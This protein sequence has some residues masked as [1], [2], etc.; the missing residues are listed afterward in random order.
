MFRNGTVRKV[1]IGVSIAALFIGVGGI[2]QASPKRGGTIIEAMGTEPTNLDIFRAARRPE[3]TILQLMIE[4]LFVTNDKLE[5]EGLL[6]E[7]GSCN[8]DASV[9]TVKLKKGIIFHDGTPLTAEA[10]K[11]SMERH[12]KGSSGK[13][14]TVVKEIK[15]VDELTVEFTLKKGYFLFLNTLSFARLGIVSP[16]AVEKAGNEWG[17]KVI[18][19]TGPLKFEKWVSGDRVIMK[20]FDNYT[21]APS[22]CSNKGPAYVDTYI[23]RFIPEPAT[24]IA[25]LT[26]GDV[27]LSDYVTGRD[28]R[29]VERHPATN[30]IVSD[31]TA[32]AYLAI[33]CDKNNYPYTDVRVR[34]AVSLAINKK[35]VI[36][37]ALAGVGGTLYTPISPW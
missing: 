27:D 11:F 6:A 20:R 14:I 18:V 1:I 16:T 37:A 22:F 7:S 3:R 24:M 13:F 26:D 29:K 23:I 12:M 4:P 17:S 15:A 25:E 8:E 5:L 21:H 9:W 19:G 2:C 28:A 35:A 30:L 10:V 36:K 31:S 33:N 34:R 32:P